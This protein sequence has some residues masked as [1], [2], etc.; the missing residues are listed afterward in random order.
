MLKKLG[1]TAPSWEDLSI[2]LVGSLSAL[3]LAGAAWAWWDR[4]RVDPWTLQMERLRQ[5][6][7]SA[8]LEAAAH[9]A[10]RALAAQLRQRFGA[11][12]EPL[13]RLLDTLERQ[14]YSRTPAARPDTALTRSFVALARRLATD[15][16]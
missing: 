15:R 3:A 14:R 5:A 11:G 16:G 6:L 7:R 2:L 4:R 1:F 13:A 8:G 12:G 10:P 9:E